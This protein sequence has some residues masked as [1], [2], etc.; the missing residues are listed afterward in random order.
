MYK[1]R[2]MNLRGNTIKIEKDYE[3]WYDNY[4][5]ARPHL[6]NKKP[7]EIKP[8]HRW[9]TLKNAANAAKVLAM[10]RSRLAAEA[11]ASNDDAAAKVR[12]VADT[13]DGVAEAGVD[14]VEAE[15]GITGTLEDAQEARS[16]RESSENTEEKEQQEKEEEEEKE[17]EAEGEKEEE[18]EG[19]VTDGLEVPAW[20]ATAAAPRWT[21]ALRGDDEFAHLVLLSFIFTCIGLVAIGALAAYRAFRRLRGVMRTVRSHLKLMED[22]AA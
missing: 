6:S 1:K 15:T 2:L 12:V 19:A 16:T 21:S 7:S 17:E 10:R 14:G 3:R 4:R 22:T 8:V 18:E 5:R 13:A 9:A 20:K 11:P